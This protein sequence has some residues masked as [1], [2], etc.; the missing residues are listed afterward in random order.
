MRNQ[1]GYSNLCKETTHKRGRIAWIYGR[2]INNTKNI[3]YYIYRE[4][5]EC[6]TKFVPKYLLKHNNLEDKSTQKLVKLIDDDLQKD[7]FKS[8]DKEVV[9]E[10]QMLE[11]LKQFHLKHLEEIRNPSDDRNRIMTTNLIKRFCN[12]GCKGTGFQETNYS[13]QELDNMFTTSL[14]DGKLETREKQRTHIKKYV[15]IR[16]T[17]RNKNKK[18]LDADDFYH[19]F[20]PKERVELKKHG[21][22]SGC[23]YGEGQ[24]DS[25]KIKGP[26]LY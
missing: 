24:I 25:R 3:L 21:A 7:H 5:E 6:K 17:L 8:K 15:N 22:I 19:K 16:K 11:K 20:V 12:P 13:K 2:T 4:M 1:I 9:K 14:F 26:E 10:K 23:A 18:I